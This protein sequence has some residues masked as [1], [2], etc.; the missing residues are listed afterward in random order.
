M[1]KH[2]KSRFPALNCSRRNEDVATDT[3]FSDTPAID[4]GSKCAQFFVGRESLVADIYPMKDPKQFVSTLE[5]NIR[6]RG[7]MNRLISDR[8]QSEI[9]NKAKD[10]L[11]ALFIDEWQ[12]EPHHQHQ[13]YAERRYG[14]IK[15]RTNLILN[16][17][18][19]PASCWLLC[20]YYVCFLTNHLSTESLNWLTPLQVL[21][22]ETTDISILLQ[23]VFYEKVYFSRVDSQ[24]PSKSTEEVGYFVGFADS[25]G[26]AMTF[27]VLT[28]DTNKIVYRS[29]VRSAMDT[30]KQNKRLEKPKKEPNVI[31]IKSQSEAGNTSVTGLNPLP[32]FNPS[33]LIGRSYLSIPE[34]DGQ[35][36]RMR[37]IKA[38][39]DHQEN[40]DKH[41]ER[42]KFMVQCRDKEKE[43]ILTYN[44]IVDHINRNIAEE[45]DIAN[46]HI[47][48]KSMVL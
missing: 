34:E 24:F 8:A 27:K 31:F 23:L 32:G 38:I 43:E 1:R 20:L 11:R 12:S 9:S 26:D 13:N 4:N 30:A 42:I 25:V 39:T 29:N 41:P 46:Q 18:G 14:T 47:K 17:T 10:L 15:S 33:E 16:R 3:I 28:S 35:K 2:Y 7:A 37:I 21:T 22:G 36:F 44:D 48:F 19:A 6:R 5:D 45:D 40:I